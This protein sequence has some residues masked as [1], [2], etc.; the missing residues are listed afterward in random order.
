MVNLNVNSIAWEI[1]RKTGRF[2]AHGEFIY[3]IDLKASLADM[4]YV[5]YHFLIDHIDR[6]RA[7]LQNVKLR[8]RCPGL[9]LDF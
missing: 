9:Y 8:H 4:S 6:E 2:L 1:L 7:I 5:V 3:Y